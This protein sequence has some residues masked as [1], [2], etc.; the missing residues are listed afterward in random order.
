M[1]P[2]V[3]ACVV[4]L[5]PSLL[6]ST[7]PLAGTY[8]LPRALAEPP[9]DLQDL[10]FP[11]AAPELV[12]LKDRLSRS[13]QNMDMALKS[14]LELLLWL[15]T[16]LLQD[17]P[18]LQILCPDAWIWTTPIFASLQYKQWAARA[19]ELEAA[20]TDSFIDERE[21]LPEKIAEIGAAQMQSVAQR[22]HETTLASQTHADETREVVH[23]LDARL[24]QSLQQGLAEVDHRQDLRHQVLSGQSLSSLH[25]S[26]PPRSLA[27][28][29]FT[30]LQ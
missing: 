26:T 8:F 17:A 19:L 18:F 30:S 22:I 9:V 25:V 6:T 16:V 15:R 29:Y 24:Q 13:Q 11:W 1:R 23:L 4:L 2:E 10:I 14:H 21:L 3:R 5:S 12:A 7:E 20:A 27:E 28:H